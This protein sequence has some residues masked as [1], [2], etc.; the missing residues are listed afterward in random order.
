MSDDPFSVAELKARRDRL[1][2]LATA[3]EPAAGWHAGD[4][5]TDPSLAGFLEGVVLRDA[6]VLIAVSDA[7]AG[8]SVL[9]TRRT[10]HL[11][12]HAGQVAFPGGKVDPGDSGPVGAA[13]REAEEEIGLRAEAVEPLGLLDPYVSNSGYRIVPVVAV[14]Q[15]GIALRPNPDEVADVFEVPLSFLMRPENHILETRPFRGLDR[16]TY[17]MPWQ[18][19]RIWGV[20]AGIV[21]LMHDQVYA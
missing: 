10:D 18:G 5:I 6:A 8:A 21:R 14:V 9:F 15:P 1:R 16:R 4:H 12:S 13:L 2:P 11:A 20:T 19:R 3:A 17:A 7:G